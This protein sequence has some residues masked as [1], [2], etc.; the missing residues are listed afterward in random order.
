VVGVDFDVLVGDVLLFESD[1]DALHEGAEPA[2]IQLQ[3]VLG[4]MVLTVLEQDVIQP[5]LVLPWLSS[6]RD[7]WPQGASLRR[8][9]LCP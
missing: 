6:L 2:R 1:P 4:F 3:W 7:Q 9:G 8:D 5:E